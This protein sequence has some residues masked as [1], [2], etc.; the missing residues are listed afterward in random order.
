MSRPSTSAT[1]PTDETTSRIAP[2]RRI[3]GRFGLTVGLLSLLAVDPAAA[4]TV[5]TAFCESDMALTVRNL[6]T[7]IQFGGPLIGG[8]LALGAT[9]ALPMVPRTDMKKELKEIRNQ[10]VIWGVI[11]APLATT[12]LQFILNNVVAGGT[13]CGF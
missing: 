9:V 11:V 4:Q 3:V 13:S 1:V 6:F 7:V 5:G 8:V 2:W 12:I 10:G